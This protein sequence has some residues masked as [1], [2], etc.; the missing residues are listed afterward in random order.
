MGAAMPVF[1]SLFRFW[2][3]LSIVEQ[4]GAVE[5]DH[6]T[7]EHVGEESIALLQ[8]RQ[9]VFQ[10]HNVSDTNED[11]WW[12]HNCW[13]W[14]DPDSLTGKKYIYYV[15]G[16]VQKNRKCVKQ[17]YSKGGNWCW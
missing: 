8:S 3:V 17:D 2:V 5:G 14:C 6:C 4:G 13:C 11:T 10:M 1:S 9:S 7:G 15:T 16:Q 12:K